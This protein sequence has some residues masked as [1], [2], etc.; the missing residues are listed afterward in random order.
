MIK[1]ADIGITLST[2]NNN[3][4]AIL[5]FSNITF[6]QNDT[7]YLQVSNGILEEIIPSDISITTFI[8]WVVS[9]YNILPNTNA[10]ASKDSN[11]LVFLGENLNLKIDFGVNQ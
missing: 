3:E 2:E 10:I 5:D 9:I 6:S 7:L 11:H 8:D 4:K 1:V